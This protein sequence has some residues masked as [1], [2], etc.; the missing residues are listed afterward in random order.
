M[1]E[2]NV[3]TPGLEERSLAGAGPWFGDKTERYIHRAV[4]NKAL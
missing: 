2:I 1:A 4:V 3:V